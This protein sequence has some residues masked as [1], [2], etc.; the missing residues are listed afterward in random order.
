MTSGQPWTAPSSAGTFLS[1]SQGLHVAW[2]LSFTFPRTL[3]SETVPQCG[4]RDL[5]QPPFTD[6]GKLAIDCTVLPG[7][8]FVVPYNC[9]SAS[10]RA[11]VLTQFVRPP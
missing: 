5:E 4:P 8:R 1:G 6:L 2:T 11:H 3:L 9:L 7:C 10:A